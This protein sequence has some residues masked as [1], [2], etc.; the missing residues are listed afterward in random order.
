MR[1]RLKDQIPTLLVALLAGTFGV[2]LLHVTGMLAVAIAADSVTG[3]SDTVA[4]M[5]PVVAWVF[6]V[7][8]IY[9]SAV[10]TSNTVAT[11]VAGRTRLIALL[12]LIGSSARAERGRI[13][14]EGL[15]VGFAGAAAG[16]LLG[17]L[18]AFGL[19]RVAVATGVMP[20][21]D[22]QYLNVSVLLPAIA[23]VLTTWLASWVGSR[24]VLRV[25]PIEAIGQSVES[26]REELVRRRGRNIAAVVLVVLGTALLAAGIVVGLVRPEG[27]LIG[28]LGGILSFSGV[29]LAAHVVMPPV[30]RLVGRLFGRSPA[31]RIA[32]E[33]AVRNPER[34]SRMTIGLV[35]GV[36]L[37]TT[38]SVTMESYRA[39][40]HAAIEAQPEVFAG[41]E[42][43]LNVTIA[44]FAVLIGFSALI[45][46]IGM[47]NTLSLSVL[48][49]TRELGLL[50]ALGFEARQL[51]GMIVAE[52]AALTVAATL[53]GLVLGF[54]YGWAGAQAL[55]GGAQGQPVFIFPGIPWAMIG[56]LVVA[57]GL[58]TAVASIA[59]A[60]RAMRVSPVVAL[61]TD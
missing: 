22:Y 49:R 9:V 11:V 45:A 33:N 57:A 59:P 34:A 3:E 26:G 61:A 46:A 38:F 10:V 20:A 12:R 23:V 40:I 1:A 2:L 36:T 58:L 42:G 48:Q 51:R 52:A 54:V 55:L 7:I 50:R 31:A 13:A 56:I 19:E 30:L 18:A 28:L 47:V 41:V 17:T 15:A 24:R 60:R 14:R 35:I 8:A 6:I 39:M 4:L 16:V 25:R 53:T 5:L 21:V 29:V 43:M 32:A 44:I 27:V 37:V